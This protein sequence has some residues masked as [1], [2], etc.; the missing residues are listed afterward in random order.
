ME[1]RNRRP[2]RGVN[3]Y[4]G[5]FRVSCPK[6]Y[7]DFVQGTTCSYKTGTCLSFLQ[8]ILEDGRSVRKQEMTKSSYN[9]WKCGK[10]KS[11]WDHLMRLHYFLPRLGILLTLSG[12]LG[13]SESKIFFSIIH[14]RGYIKVIPI[15]S[16]FFTWKREKVNIIKALWFCCCYLTVWNL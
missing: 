13:G 1:G 7:K 4:V 6:A 9:F 15:R 2:R 11:G 16:L 8:G 10:I 3:S 12:S 14:S 5:F